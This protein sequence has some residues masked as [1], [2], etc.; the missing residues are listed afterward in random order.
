MSAP[1][2]SGLSVELLLQVVDVKNGWFTL[3]YTIMASVAILIITKTQ[4][5][6]K[7]G[8]RET[9]LIAI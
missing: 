1:S 3:L 7:E 5:A 9:I 4:F 2:T 6:S 8:K